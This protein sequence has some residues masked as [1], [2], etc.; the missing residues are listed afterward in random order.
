VSRVIESTV[1]G[2]GRYCRVRG[3][4]G[5]EC[6]E[7]AEGEPVPREVGMVPTLEE[8]YRWLSHEPPQPRVWPVHFLG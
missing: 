7:W 1:E 8:A 4:C 3:R 6:M 5:F 2:S